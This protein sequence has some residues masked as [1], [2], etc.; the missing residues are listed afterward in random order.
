MS[1]EE[2]RAAMR[3][4]KKDRASKKVCWPFISLFLF[5]SFAD[6]SSLKCFKKQSEMFD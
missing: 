5:F 4:A 6:D 1:K 3:K 2:M